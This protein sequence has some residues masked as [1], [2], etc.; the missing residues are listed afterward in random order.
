MNNHIDSE[1]LVQFVDDRLPGDQCKPVI[2]H[3][4]Q[5]RECSSIYLTLHAAKARLAQPLPERPVI[6][7]QVRRRMLARYCGS[8][9]QR[10]LRRWR[11]GLA[12]AAALLLIVSGLWGWHWLRTIAPQASGV[13]P[14]V[15][16]RK[17]PDSAQQQ[18]SRPDIPQV[19]QPASPSIQPQVV[20]PQ[21]TRALAMAARTKHLA[22][23][24]A[25]TQPGQAGEPESRGATVGR[26]RFVSGNPALISEDHSETLQPGSRV[27]SEQ[28]LRTGAVDR[29]VIELPGRGQLVVNF[30]TEVK[31]SQVGGSAIG[32]IQVDLR[33][34]RLWAWSPGDGQPIKVIVPE[35]VATVHRAEAIIIAGSSEDALTGPIQYS[36]EV[37]ALRGTVQF[38][39]SLEEHISIPAEHVLRLRTGAKLQPRQYPLAKLVRNPSVWGRQ[40]E[41]WQFVPVSPVDLVNELAAPRLRLGVEIAVTGASG[42]GLEVATVAPETAAAV[43]GL[44]PG[45]RLL[46]IAGQPTN[47]LVDLACGEIELAVS[48]K[49]TITIQQGK[50]TRSV[51]LPRKITPPQLDGRQSDSPLEIATL[52]RE[53]KLQ[54]AITE[55]RQETQ[56][57]PDRAAGWF[58]RGLIEEHR[59]RYEQALDC[60]GQAAQLAGASAPV[61]AAM[62]RAYAQLGNVNRAISSLRQSLQLCEAPNNRYL[63]GRIALLSGNLSLAERTADQLLESSTIEDR[64]W[65]HALTGTIL[66]V[67]DESL[68]PAAEHFRTAL[69]LCLSNLHAAHSLAGVLLGLG[70]IDAAEQVAAALVGLQ[71]NSVRTVNTM[72]VI[73]WREKRWDEAEQWFQ[74]AE[75]LQVFSQISAYNMASVYADQGQSQ[76]AIHWYRLAL[77][78]D[79]S[80]LPAH[81]SLAKTLSN[82]NNWRLALYHLHRALAID[83]GSALA[84]L[85]LAQ[86]W[87]DQGYSD[88]AQDVALHY[89]LETSSRGGS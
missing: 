4:A 42:P 39:T 62:G 59:G 51:E 24:K 9:L 79:A 44:Q 15:I 26:I 43:V 11:P 57:H 37:M 34:G 10:A 56:Q 69:S 61:L 6:S 80:F 1:T 54:Q 87:K 36:P 46:S 86:L 84:Y 28:V 27:R 25:H 38:A 48:R 45:D 47:T 29:A 14:A 19:P 23:P 88:R 32:N 31:L 67:A 78:R 60:Y 82:Q 66:R 41:L 71:P 72:G 89:D 85:R 55:A 63:L 7:E 50:G 83:P 33:A 30:D 16:F 21:T 35:G 53:H 74:R 22:E 49:P 40:Y 18:V 81:V 75:G 58:N 77:Q 3:L 70:Q 2:Q 68:E 73:A 17:P 12:T 20:T 52:M 8:P 13:P 65:G 64:A 76:Q 5:C